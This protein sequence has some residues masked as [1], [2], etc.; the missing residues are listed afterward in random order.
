MSF[1][2]YIFFLV[3]LI[4]VSGGNLYSQK[5]AKQLNAK[6]I[7]L[8]L[9]FPKSNV[10]NVVSTH[11][12]DSTMD[13]IVVIKNQTD[14][15]ASFYQDWNSW[16]FYNTNFEIIAGDSVYNLSRITA[17]WDKNI[18]SYHILSPGDSLILQYNIEGENCNP[19]RFFFGMP[20]ISLASAKV[21]AIYQL[22]DLESHT[23]M[24]ATCPNCY[25]DYRVRHKN[26]KG[27]KKTS[28][29]IVRSFVTAKLVSKN[30]EIRFESIEKK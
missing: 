30:Y 16:G 24:A 22:W 26:F 18:P 27:K 3:F 8:T 14:T 29:E 1:R 20:K 11:C 12:E 17:G 15:V 13:V 9:S 5:I 25:Q 10:E 7:T 4:F 2:F 28:V 23:S 6:E 19:F 21:R